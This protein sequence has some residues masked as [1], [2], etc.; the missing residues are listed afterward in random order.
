ML[1]AEDLLLLLTD[2]ET[3]K[4]AASGTE[5]DVALGGAL[6]VELALKGRVDVAGANDRVRE[7][8]LVVRN[9]D[10]T[11]DGELDEALT[12][13]V[14]REGKKPQSVVTRLGKRAR[15]RLYQ[16]LVERGV[17][18]VEA[19]RILGIFPTHRWPSNDAAHESS[20]RT[21]LLTALREGA[22]AEA[23]TGA[24]ISLL[25]ALNAVHKTVAPDSLG[26]SETELE[27]S[28]KRIAEGD[29]AA[30]AVRQAIDS[31]NAAVIAAT[32]SAVI[33]GGGGGSS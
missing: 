22:A 11:G 32:S 18:R 24:L 2:D 17:L 23:R 15:V 4:L 7:G 13:V 6:L 1:L 14:E 19:D 16:R 28:A 5:V 26:L 25:H 29:W 12:L 21:A 10:P 20:V 3:G 27:A 9:P 31:I 30:K 8:R 33:V